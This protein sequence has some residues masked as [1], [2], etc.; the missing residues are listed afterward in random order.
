MIP[1]WPP[2]RTNK[3]ANCQY[4]PKIVGEYC[5][6][7]WDLNNRKSGFDAN[8]NKIKYNKVVVRRK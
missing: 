8:N 5:Q 6:E 2:Y 7:C 1:S 4:K 3:C